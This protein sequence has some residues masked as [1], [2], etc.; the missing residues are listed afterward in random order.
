MSNYYKNRL[1]W[2]IKKI[3]NKKLRKI[4]TLF[5]RIIKQKNYYLIII[6]NNSKNHH[7]KENSNNAQKLIK[8]NYIYEIN[9]NL[10]QYLSIKKVN[11]LLAYYY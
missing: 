7:Q 2:N 11:D 5:K 6:K 4:L 9:K 10:E 3:I 8:N 1:K